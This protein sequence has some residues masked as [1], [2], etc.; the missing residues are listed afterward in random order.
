MRESR[1]TKN[2]NI[3]S[4]LLSSKKEKNNISGTFAVIVRNRSINQLP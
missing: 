1:G 4:H 2:L 3:N